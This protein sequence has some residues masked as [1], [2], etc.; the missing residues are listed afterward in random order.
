MDIASTYILL[1]LV[2]M[3]MMVTVLIHLH[4]LQEEF[5][6]QNTMKIVRNL[7]TVLSWNPFPQQFPQREA[8]L[9]GVNWL[10]TLIR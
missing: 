8:V 2:V 1:F 5:L 3:L 6:D 4:F 9:Q 10:F 7:E